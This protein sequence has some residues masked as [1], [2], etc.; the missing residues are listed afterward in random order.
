MVGKEATRISGISWPITLEIPRVL[1]E[2]LLL[3][4]PFMLAFVPLWFSSAWRPSNV[5]LYVL[6][7]VYLVENTLLMGLAFGVVG[8]VM[9]VCKL[10]LLCECT[11]FWYIFG[12]GAAV[13]VVESRGSSTMLGE[14]KSSDKRDLEMKYS[15]QNGDD[16]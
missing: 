5:E 13:G 9:I 12:A 3:L 10:M 1:S 14:F 8:V 16:E 2:L 11:K 6:N 4:F 7:S 15:T